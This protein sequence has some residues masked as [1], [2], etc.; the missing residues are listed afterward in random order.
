M[1]GVIKIYLSGSIKKGR[2]D[3]RGEDAFWSPAH[4]EE[5]RRLVIEPVVLL[6][7]A[8]TSIKRNDYFVNYGCDLY[9]VGHADCVLV[10][11]RMERGIGVGAE[12]MYARVIN[13]PVIGWLPPNSVYRRDLI[14]DVFGEDLANWTHPFA[15]GLCD[16]IA[17]NLELACQQI[18]SMWAEGEL[19]KDEAKS[20]EK[21]IA[22]F[23][24]IYG[25]T[26]DRG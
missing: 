5:I 13:K 26:I 21:A 24:D 4:E 11:L 2:T 14:E 16:F 6:N 7:P 12:L 15:F 22:A 18:N 17:D 19:R 9:L 20:P 10:D 1:S 8:K 25:D 23:L 3:N